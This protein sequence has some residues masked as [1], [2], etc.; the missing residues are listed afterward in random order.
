M[1]SDDEHS[2]GREYLEFTKKG[3]AAL[4]GSLTAHCSVP[5]LLPD[6]AVAD[7]TAL[8]LVFLFW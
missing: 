7:H 8:K 5:P 4:F 2:Y 1:V 3:D 6:G